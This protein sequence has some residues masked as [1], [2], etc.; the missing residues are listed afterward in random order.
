MTEALNEPDRIS[1]LGENRNVR[2]NGEGIQVR[3]NAKWMKPENETI[4]VDCDA[5]WAASTSSAGIG[6]LARNR[7]GRVEAGLAKLFKAGS[8]TV[9]EALAA[10]EGLRCAVERQRSAVI[11]ETDSQV[12]YNI[13]Q[14]SR[15]IPHG[16]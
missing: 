10:R 11:V 7:E 14:L 16:I 1:D 9:A 6:V 15:D 8:A 2:Q 12:M 13:L 4:K 5:A 3:N